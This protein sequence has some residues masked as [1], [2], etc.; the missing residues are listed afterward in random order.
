VN[1]HSPCPFALLGRKT[2]AAAI[3]DF[4]GLDIDGEADET[5]LEIRSMI[6]GGRVSPYCE[7]YAR[8]KRH[9]EGFP[10]LAEFLRGDTG[11]LEMLEATDSPEL[12]K[13]PKV[14]DPREQLTIVGAFLN[15]A[16]YVLPRTD[17]KSP[18]ERVETLRRMGTPPLRRSYIDDLAVRF[19]IPKS[20]TKTFDDETTYADGA[21]C[22]EYL[23][24]HE[25][26]MPRSLGVTVEE[27]VSLAD[28]EKTARIHCYGHSPEMLETIEELLG[29][30]GGISRECPRAANA[31]LMLEEKRIKKI[32]DADRGYI[33]E[34]SELFARRRDMKG[35]W[36]E[37]AVIWGIA[38]FIVC[39]A[40]RAVLGMTGYPGD[41][42][43]VGLGVAMLFLTL[44]L[45]FDAFGGLDAEKRALKRQRSL[46]RDDPYDQNPF[47]R[48][49]MD[50]NY[51]TLGETTRLGQNHRYYHLGGTLAACILFALY[52][53]F[54]SA[55]PSIVRTLSLAFP[56]FGAISGAGISYWL[57]NFKMR[58]SLKEIVRACDLL[59][60]EM[61]DDKFEVRGRYR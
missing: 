13:P 46:A 34:L 28:Y 51:E 25:L 35:K 15:P 2:D 60:A 45:L 16:R 17:A 54:Q 33:K 59:C 37:N 31:A 21:R 27:D 53:A 39:A 56:I 3:Y 20:L 47:R 52:G 49:R 9:E 18:A 43:W 26:L 61:M 10:E 57:Y 48:A 30:L 38:S 24:E 41:E 5:E 32:S 7:E 8:H 58:R 4:I 23:R 19:V 22:L 40:A 36:R 42:G 44:A 11:P 12:V 50:E 55:V 6:N 14:H 29:E 1:A